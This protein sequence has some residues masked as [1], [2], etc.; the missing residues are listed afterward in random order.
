MDTKALTGIPGAGDLKVS[1]VTNP[2]T[3]PLGAA[4][5]LTPEQTTFF[6]AQIGIND[7]DNLKTHML[8][9]Q[10]K[11]YKVSEVMLV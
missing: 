5:G 6:K 11:G 9:V 4:Y 7:D 3:E 1:A 8:E 2:D 10:E